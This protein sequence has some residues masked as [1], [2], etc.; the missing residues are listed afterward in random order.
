M[1]KNRLKPPP[2]EVYSLHRKLSGS[3]LACMRLN[4]RIDCSKIWEEIKFQRLI[5]TIDL[6]EKTKLV[7]WVHHNDLM[8]VV[9]K[10]YLLYM[11]QMNKRSDSTK[12]KYFIKKIKIESI[13]PNLSFHWTLEIFGWNT[14]S[15]ASSNVI[16]R[17]SLNLTLSFLYPQSD[18]LCLSGSSSLTILFLSI[19]YA[20]E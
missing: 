19:L 15:F 5:E 14:H 1:L 11:K 18:L 10:F 6:S 16:I 17:F 13:W 12:I 7:L 3:Y 9:Y 8:L 20:L 4:A 2:E